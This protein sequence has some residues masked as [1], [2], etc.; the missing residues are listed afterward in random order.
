MSPV[1]EEEREGTGATLKR[2]VSNRQN[3]LMACLDRQCNMKFGTEAKLLT[4]M[5]THQD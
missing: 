3:K 4:H 2:R 1:M 5:K